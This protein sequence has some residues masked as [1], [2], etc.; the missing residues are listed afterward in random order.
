MKLSIM[1]PYLFPYIGYFQLIAASDRF[2]FYDDVNYIK[3]GWINRNRILERGRA[4]TFSV[5]LQGASSF[6]PIY[7]TM[8]DQRQ[9]KR[10]KTKFL[11]TLTLNYRKAPHHKEALRL[12][13]AVLEEEVDNIADL[14]ANSVLAVAKYLELPG[15]I[16]KTSRLY[17]N[18][19][20]R[21]SERVLD[22]CQREGASTYLNAIGGQE[23]Y[24]PEQFRAA[25]FE[26]KFVRSR[27]IGYPQFGQE[28]VPHLSIIDVLMFTTRDEAR[29]L[30]QEYDLV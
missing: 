8:I 4:L 16:V 20:L 2:V 26:L 11:Q 27:Q 18:G 13:Q 25:G 12:V 1:Q 28:F 23:I 9:Y 15:T 24:S 5:P 3:Q 14:A 19:D 6:T 30:L 21:S 7:K 29:C 17:D 10:W 22:I